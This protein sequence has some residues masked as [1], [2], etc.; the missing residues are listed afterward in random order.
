MAAAIDA[1]SGVVA[2]TFTLATL[3]R[4]D[5][6]TGAGDAGGGVPGAMASVAV[7]SSR[8]MDF[9]REVALEFVCGMRAEQKLVLHPQRVIRAEARAAAV[10]VLQTHLRIFARI[11]GHVW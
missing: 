5:G 3:V 11:P 7:A 2:T 1:R 8:S 10:V 9:M 4:G 6:G